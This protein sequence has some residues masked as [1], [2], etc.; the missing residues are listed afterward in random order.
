M[1]WFKVDDRLYSHPKWLAT[2]HKS[3]ALWLTACSWCA[4]HE[5]DAFSPPYVLST[6]RHPKRD[7]DELV[8]TR[9]WKQLDGG[10]KFKDR[11]DYQ[12]TSAEL[13]EKRA[14]RAEAG[15]RGGLASGRSRREASASAS[16]SPDA[17]HGAKQKGTPTRPDPS[18]SK[19][20]DMGAPKRA[21]QI[22]KSWTPTKEHY[23]RAKKTALNFK[24]ETE[25][26]RNHAL[27]KGR[28]SK[29]WNLAFTNW[30]I[31]AAEY[32]DRNQGPQSTADRNAYSAWGNT[33]PGVA[34]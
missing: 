8:H 2:S 1:A 31:K 11:A 32:A 9:L 34:S 6:F 16:A 23:E 24:A 27:E 15:R 10:W 14:A 25:K 30:L 5:Q 20:V 18:T 3:H 4:V 13:S 22:P 29:N 17:S 33:P 7:I 19:E 28:T 26:F 12:P 21:T